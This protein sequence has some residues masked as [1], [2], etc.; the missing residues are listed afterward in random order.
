MHHNL[1]YGIFKMYFFLKKYIKIVF[2][3]VSILILAGCA[4]P[5]VSLNQEFWT[6]Q[7]KPVVAVAMNKPPQADAFFYGGGLL[8][9]AIIIA[10]NQKFIHYLNQYDISSLNILPD[11]FVQNLQQRGITAK[12]YH[13]NID[14]NK[15]KNSSE[16][17]YAAYERKDFTPLFSQLNAD[18]LL[19]INV[20]FVGA[21]RRYY[22]V[23]PLGPPSAICTIEGRLINLKTNR[24]LWRFTIS[25]KV[26]VVGPW[27]Q[28]PSYS[29][30]SNALNQVMDQAK[31]IV[32]S[33]FFSTHSM[34]ITSVARK[35]QDKGVT[36]EN[37]LK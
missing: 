20:D 9:I 30:F 15:L 11:Q 6:D 19:L 5:N 22:G 31:Q 23:I 2:L 1:K 12:H 17:N 29:N 3:L 36:D 32:L 8:D 24:T 33:N 35:V 21:I 13:E 16:P 10:E 7:P 28:P 34:P 4:D 26:Q 14:L 25:Q 18:Q 37:N 27:S